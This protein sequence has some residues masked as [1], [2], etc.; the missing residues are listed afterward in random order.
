M[1]GT[2]FRHNNVKCEEWFPECFRVLKDGGH[3]YI[4]CN[5]TNLYEFLTV[6][7][8]CG[9]HFIKSLIWNKGNKVA[10]LYYMNSF[11]YILFFR[12]GKAVKINNCGTADVLDVPN[13]KLKDEHGNNLHDTSKPVELMEIL[14][15]NSSKQGEVV[16]DFAFGIGT[17]AIA[18]KKLN[19][20][21]VGCEI[22]P[23]YYNIAVGRLKEIESA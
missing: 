14:I 16:C 18:C 10:G 20:D 6:A 8:N 13:V 2:V 23:K 22:D 5:H 3:C 9:F 15:E 1:D 17:T 7:Q 12:K 19:R 21:F 4:M 11:E